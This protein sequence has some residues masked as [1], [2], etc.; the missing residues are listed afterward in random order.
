MQINYCSLCLFLIN[1]AGQAQ[2]TSTPTHS[3][4]RSVDF[5]SKSPGFTLPWLFLVDYSPN[6]LWHHDA[7]AVSLRGD[8]STIP[9]NVGCKNI[10][11]THTYN[12]VQKAQL[13]LNP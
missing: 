10:P 11:V 12:I 3:N 1:G 7:V 8:F 13:L 9:G 6:F 5:Q 4:P 2:R